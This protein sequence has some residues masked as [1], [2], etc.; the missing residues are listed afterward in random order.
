MNQTGSK[1]TKIAQSE[2]KRLESVRN[3]VVEWNS[4]TVKDSGDIRRVCQA[5]RVWPVSKESRAV[6][7]KCELLTF[8]SSINSRDVTFVVLRPLAVSHAVLELFDKNHAVQVRLLVKVEGT[9]PAIRGYY[10]TQATI[11]TTVPS[12]PQHVVFN[13]GYFP[14][15]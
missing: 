2:A 14:N 11:L 15:P 10:L 4:R 9:I 6:I 3:C 8:V 1:R 5:A 12:E 7:P 13:H